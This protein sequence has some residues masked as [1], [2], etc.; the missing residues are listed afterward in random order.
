VYEQGSVQTGERIERA[1]GG[2]E[3]RFECTGERMKPFCTRKFWNILDI[4]RQ[5][6]QKAKSG[7]Q[8]SH[9]KQK[10]QNQEFGV[11]GQ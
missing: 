11:V 6:V 3:E 5:S 10:N 8:L 2:R 9:P 1:T 4:H 7:V